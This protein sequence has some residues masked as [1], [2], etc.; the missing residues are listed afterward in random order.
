[1]NAAVEDRP[2]PDQQA[3]PASYGRLRI[4]CPNCGKPS[5]GY[6]TRP[7]SAITTEVAYDCTTEGCGA[8]FV[9]TA[10][11]SRY[12]RMPANINTAVNVP[13]SPVV[14]RRKLIEAIESM[15]TAKLPPQG[16]IVAPPDSLRQSDLFAAPHGP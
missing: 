7:L 10:E 3:A 1:M 6:K 4:R 11:V 12:I 5:R 13:I 8:G 15:G 2:T 16:E 14:E 9:V